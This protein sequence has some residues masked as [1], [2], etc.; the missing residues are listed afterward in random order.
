MDVGVDD[1]DGDGDG[2]GDIV[3]AL[4]A[5]SSLIADADNPIT[6][7]KRIGN[8]KSKIEDID[9]WYTEFIFFPTEPSDSRTRRVDA[10][11]RRWKDPD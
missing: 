8:G 4:M 11:K 1:D 2:E 3:K 6:T 9:L 5:I 7:T 10:M